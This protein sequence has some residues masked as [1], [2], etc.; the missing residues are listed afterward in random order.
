V[1]E[2]EVVAGADLLMEGTDPFID[3][4]GQAVKQLEKT[5]G[6]LFAALVVHLPD[7]PADDWVF[8]AGSKQL[9]K[10][11]LDGIRAIVKAL[12]RA[13]PAKY[14]TRI[15]RVDVLQS[16]D[17]VYLHLSRAFRIEPGATAI[18][19]SCNIFG[20]EIE[21]GVIFAM[22]PVPELKATSKVS[23]RQARRRKA[24]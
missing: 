22:G 11:R 6:P 2:K 18:L 21:R 13:V 24:I 17:Q 12:K 19:R 7:R 8:L 1:A 20:V 14:A 15:R 9:E 16:D 10:R 4:V 3:E 23:S 5:H